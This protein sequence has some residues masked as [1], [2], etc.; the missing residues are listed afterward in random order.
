MGNFPNMEAI[1]SFFAI[2]DYRIPPEEL[3]NA[4]KVLFEVPFAMYTDSWAKLRTHAPRWEAA[5]ESQKNMCRL[6]AKYVLL[7]YVKR[8]A[9]SKEKQETSPA[10]TDREARRERRQR[11]QR[12]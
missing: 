1:D 8:I 3:E 6:Q 7:Q 12:V 4:A 11:R 9:E 5:T 2:R 10:A